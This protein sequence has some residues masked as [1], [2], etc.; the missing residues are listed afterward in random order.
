[1]EYICFIILVISQAHFMIEYICSIIL[2]FPH[3]YFVA[4][5]L[6]GVLWWLLLIKLLPLCAADRTYFDGDVAGSCNERQNGRI[7]R[8]LFL[9]FCQSDGQVGAWL[10]W[11]KSHPF[12]VG[13]RDSDFFSCLVVKAFRFLVV[14]S[15][16]RLAFAFPES[17]PAS[18]QN[19]NFYTSEGVQI[20]T[21]VSNQNTS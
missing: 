21:G 6:L 19:S 7:R 11:E 17:D 15:G 16:Q 9:F 10:G 13:R 5:F 20:D 4:L 2:I 1:M 8:N 12:D 18:S 14:E 3:L